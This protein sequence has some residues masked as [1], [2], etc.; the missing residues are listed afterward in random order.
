MERASGVVTGVRAS[1]IQEL[2]S[3]CLA[4][5]VGIDLG[6][7]NSAVAAMEGGRPTIA[8]NAEGAR[9]TPSV[10]AYTKTGDRL[11]GQVR[12][13][14]AAQ[15][16]RGH[17][18]R[19]LVACHVGAPMLVR[20]SRGCPLL[21]WKPLDAR[22]RTRPPQLALFLP[23]TA[24]YVLPA[25]FCPA[26]DRMP[27]AGAATASSRGCCTPNAAYDVCAN[28]QHVRQGILCDVV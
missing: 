20:P 9:T 4:Q 1:A 24:H 6:T 19:A 15:C 2:T 18:Q 25:P 8:T 12:P 10:V 13:T 22:S 14:I 21:G 23:H 5:V 11:V 16:F 3:P 27:G 28:R 17:E 7:T 26:V